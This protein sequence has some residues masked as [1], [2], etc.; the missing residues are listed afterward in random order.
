MNLK[1]SLCSTGLLL[2]SVL[3]NRNSLPLINK[4][5]KIRVEE[6]VTFPDGWSRLF[7]C[8]LNQRRSYILR[9]LPPA[10]CLPK[11]PPKLALFLLYLGL[12]VWRFEPTNTGLNQRPSGWWQSEQWYCQL[13]SKQRTFL[14]GFVGSKF[15][16]LQHLP[17][18]THK[19]YFGRSL[20]SFSTNG[21]YKR[22]VPHEG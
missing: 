3:L 11:Y 5:S 1:P 8:S 6:R 2:F 13:C 9:L 18:T 15:Y 12:V 17:P 7:I 10:I 4:I 20:C 16:S 19:C 21:I 22:M 14:C